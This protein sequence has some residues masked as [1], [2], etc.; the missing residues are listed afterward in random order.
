MFEAHSYEPAGAP[1]DAEDSTG[2]TESDAGADEHIPSIQQKDTGED[3]QS[4][5]AAF[6]SA[7]KFL[8]IDCV[9]PL[10]GE[11]LG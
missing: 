3:N 11:A 2:T 8:Y 7:H 9:E 5:P 6:K 10:E 1:P 4:L